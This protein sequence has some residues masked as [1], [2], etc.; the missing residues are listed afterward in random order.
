MNDLKENIIIEIKKIRSRNS[1]TPLVT[2]SNLT[3]KLSEATVST[4]NTGAQALKKF[5][6]ISNPLRVKIKHTAA[7]EI[8]A[9]I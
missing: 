8:K 5:R 1:I 2:D 3:R 7:E 4:K 9:I 6:T